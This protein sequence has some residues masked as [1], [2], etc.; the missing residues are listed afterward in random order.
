[1]LHMFILCTFVFKGAECLPASRTAPPLQLHT[2]R[3]GRR[4]R[5]LRALGEA[6]FG[7]WGRRAIVSLQ[8]R[9]KSSV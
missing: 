3:D 5:T 6:V 2:L 8:V 1:M 7:K 9:G 4:V